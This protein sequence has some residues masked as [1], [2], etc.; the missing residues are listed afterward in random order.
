MIKLR[1]RGTKNC[2]LKKA[3]NQTLLYCTY[4]F[5]YTVQYVTCMYVILTACVH[6]CMICIIMIAFMFRCRI[7]TY[8]YCYMQRAIYINVLSYTLKNLK[9]KK[10]NQLF[11]RSFKGTV[12]PDWICMRV[13]SLESP[14]KVHQPLYVL[15]F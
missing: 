1:K 8:L 5:T 2:K 7:H 15:N 14:L 13:V 4:S 6:L 11:K 12:R 9:E 10:E 3:L